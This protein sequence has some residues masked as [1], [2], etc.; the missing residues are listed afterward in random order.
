MC[1]RINSLRESRLD[2]LTFY[3]MTSLISYQVQC[4]KGHNQQ[5][6]I[7][8][9]SQDEYHRR[10]ICISSYQNERRAKISNCVKNGSAKC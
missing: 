2:S 3:D 7:N 6:L 4:A 5:D 10:V 1:S 9:C 8:S